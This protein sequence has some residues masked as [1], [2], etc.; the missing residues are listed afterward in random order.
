M[1]IPNNSDMGAN[2]PVSLARIV[3]ED[4]QHAGMQQWQFTK[5]SKDS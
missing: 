5:S 1:K 3:S 2:P 4:S